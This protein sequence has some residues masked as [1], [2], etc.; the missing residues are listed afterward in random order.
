MRPAL[1]ALL[2]ASAALA[3]CGARP[4]VQPGP[5]PAP[6]EMEAV[7]VEVDGQGQG[8][9]YDAATLFQE[10][11]AAHRAQDF[12]RCDQVYGQLL[13]RFPDSR[14]AHSALYNRGLCLESLKQHALAAQHFRRHAQLATEL[15]DRRDG[16]FRMGVNLLA[17]GNHAEAQH[18][19]DQLLQAEDLGPADRAECH[20]R[21]AIARTHLK[22]VGLAERDLRAAT[23]YVKE[24]YGEHLQGNDLLAEIHFQ[25]G[26][27]YE[28]L[29]RDVP[30]KLPLAKMKGD[31]AE[32]VRYFRQAQASYID[33]L[34]VRHSY[35]ATASGLKL[36][37]L[38]EH[39]YR[40]VLLAEAPADFD[41]DAK[42]YYLYE[43][44]KALTPL[45]EQSLSIYEKNI[46]LSERLGA[47]NEWVDETEARVARLRSLIEANQRAPEPLGAKE[48]KPTG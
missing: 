40:D 7:V 17:T 38:Y 5:P 23:S 19:Y 1:A 33:A 8:Q 16:E 30:L 28:Q 41:K 42:A 27:I 6:I 29:T 47:R 26:R 45:L 2:L 18:L 15:R 48:Q 20:L 44:R 32:K 24:A 4:T 10:G 39:F 25:R 9:V 21:R 14:F 43:L 11:E 35:W 36:G 12:A 31:L 13:D 46:T 22:R 3:G 34:N 37:E